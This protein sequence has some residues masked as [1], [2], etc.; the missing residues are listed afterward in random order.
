MTQGSPEHQ[1]SNR[2][3]KCPVVAGTTA[4]TCSD[5][6]CVPGASPTCEEVA[7]DLSFENVSALSWSPRIPATTYAL[8]RGMIDSGAWS[9][10]QTCLEPFLDAPTAEDTQTPVSGRIFYYLVS[11]KTSC[12]EGILGLTSSAVLRPNSSPCP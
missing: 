8:Y 4:D 12:C 6:A 11:E 2:A 1:V 10:N 9:F 5:G 3:A 7:F